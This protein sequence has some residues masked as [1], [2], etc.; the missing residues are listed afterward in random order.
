MVY[1]VDEDF[2]IVMAEARACGTPLISIDR[3]GGRFSS[4]ACRDTVRAAVTE[5]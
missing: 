4:A 2:G 1:P 3:G 5:R